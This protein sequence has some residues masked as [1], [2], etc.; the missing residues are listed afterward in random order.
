MIKEE[1][2]VC[3]LLLK[4]A[5]PK[6]TYQNLLEVLIK[7]SSSELL[8]NRYLIDTTWHK[9]KGCG[10]TWSLRQRVGYMVASNL[11][12][13]FNNIYNHVIYS[14]AMPIC[15]TIGDIYPLVFGD[16]LEKF[17]ASSL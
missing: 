4:L 16:P 11:L 14:R 1:V 2:C 10:P 5:R 3:H 9:N 6:T 15:K 13:S 12:V 17:V 8:P 7:I